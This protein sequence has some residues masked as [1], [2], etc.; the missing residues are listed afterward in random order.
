MGRVRI[1]E[2]LPVHLGHD[3]KDNLNAFEGAKFKPKARFDRIYVK[4][5]KANGPAW[6][7]TQFSFVG[8]QRILKYGRFASDHWGILCH[9]VK[10]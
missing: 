2:R 8:T 3:E 10:L 9:L 4:H 6:K 7:P 5:A 1:S